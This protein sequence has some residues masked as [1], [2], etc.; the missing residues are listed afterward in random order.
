MTTF[1]MS[2]IGQILHRN[3]DKSAAARIRDSLAAS[4]SRMPL[5][6]Y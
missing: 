1:D 4:Q 5:M 6:R 2:G 3:R